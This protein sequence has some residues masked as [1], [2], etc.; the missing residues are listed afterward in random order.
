MAPALVMNCD[1]KK[2]EGVVVDET[3]ECESC[4]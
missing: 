2:S 1:C 3:N 4:Q